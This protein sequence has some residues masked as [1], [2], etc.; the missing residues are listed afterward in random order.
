MGAT[1][2]DGWKSLAWF[3]IQSMKSQREPATTVLL[4]RSSLQRRLAPLL[5]KV[6]A[7][8]RRR[9]KTGKSQKLSTRL[10]DVSS[11]RGN[12]V[13]FES[14]KKDLRDALKRERAT[15]RSRGS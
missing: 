14:A 10:S 15:L 3:R 11:A 6:P 12:A 7:N 8:C 13:K 9:E 1:K 2:R 4:Q 5:W